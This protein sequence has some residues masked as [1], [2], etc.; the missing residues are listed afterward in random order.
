MKWSRWRQVAVPLRHPAEAAPVPIVADGAI[1]TRGYADGRLL[2]FLI[3]DT[4]ARPDIDALIL[5]HRDLRAGDASSQWGGRS[6]FDDRGIRLLIR[7][8]S[9]SECTILL[10]FDIVT[11]GGTVDRIV[12]TGGLYI[13]NGRPGD[14][15]SR[16]HSRPYISIE[17]PSKD[18][19]TEWDRIFRKAMFADYRSMGMSRA[20]AKQA[21]QGLI[22]R[23]REF[24]A[25]RMESEPIEPVGR[26]DTKGDLS[27][28]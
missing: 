5:A 21:V 22:Q 2:S 6:R 16:T 3:L 23:W 19:R 15:L 26:A 27:S 14:R 10:D 7:F 13:Q 4:T 18:F 17:I 11:Q 28:L 20:D 8:K 24:G 12:Q 25:H 1:A 9:P